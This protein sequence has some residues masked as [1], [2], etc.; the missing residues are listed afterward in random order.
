MD[1]QN[2]RNQEYAKTRVREKTW[3]SFLKSFSWR[4]SATTTTIA[5][6]WMITGDVTRALEIGGIEFFL[7][8]GIYY[9]HE[10][11]WSHLKVGQVVEKIP[12]PDYQ[13]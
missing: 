7:K 11:L 5:I 12:A 10:R 1:D 3:R 4:I 8:M 2:A 6:A 13:I 9:L